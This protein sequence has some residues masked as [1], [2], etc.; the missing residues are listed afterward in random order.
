MKTPRYKAGILTIPPQ[1]LVR[2]CCMI[3]CKHQSLQSSDGICTDVMC[4]SMIQ[5]RIGSRELMYHV[6]K[7]FD[8]GDA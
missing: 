5:V 3:I 6:S 4:N 2:E 7:T 1:F 8:F